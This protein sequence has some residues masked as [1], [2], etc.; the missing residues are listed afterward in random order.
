MCAVLESLDP[1]TRFA[2][3][4]HQGTFADV[5]PNAKYNYAADRLHLDAKCKL[6]NGTGLQGQ[7]QQYYDAIRQTF[8][9]SVDKKLYRAAKNPQSALAAK[10]AKKT[11]KPKK[12]N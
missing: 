4:L 12:R 2:V 1:L 6:L 3:E 11:A 10:K 7:S 8:S 5:R 9:D